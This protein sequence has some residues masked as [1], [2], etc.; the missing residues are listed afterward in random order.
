MSNTPTSLLHLINSDALRLV[1]E[2]AAR[3]AQVAAFSLID[4]KV[5]LRHETR[6]MKKFRLSSKT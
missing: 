1:N 4:K 3:N 2:S 6:K 5:K